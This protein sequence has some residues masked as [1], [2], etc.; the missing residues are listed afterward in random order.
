MGGRKKGCSARLFAKNF[1]SA[2]ALAWCGLN[3]NKKAVLLRP[4]RILS[5][6]IHFPRPSF[7][8][9]EPLLPDL[10]RSDYDFKCGFATTLL[11]VCHSHGTIWV[12]PTFSAK[13]K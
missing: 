1:P 3:M 13:I 6:I 2:G 8:Y 11:V 7:K 4:L 10:V 12:I 5:C 9:R